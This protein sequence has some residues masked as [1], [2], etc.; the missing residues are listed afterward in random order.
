[1]ALIDTYERSSFGG[2][3]FPFTDLSIK[4]SLDHHVHKYLHRPGG[5][6][7]NLARHLYEF[8]FNCDFHDRY[9]THPTLIPDLLRLIRLFESGE[10]QELVVPGAGTFRAKAIDWTRNVTN[11][12]RSGGRVSI[13]FMEDSTDEFTTAT[14]VPTGESNSLPQIA[15]LFKQEA[16]AMGRPDLGNR[17]V[18]SV[19]DYISA[20]NNL[21]VT[22]GGS[23]VTVQPVINTCKSIS[24]DGAFQSPR[25]AKAF[26]VLQEVGAT[27]IGIAKSNPLSPTTANKYTTLSPISVMELAMQFY[28]R[29][30]RAASLLAINNFTDA[31]RIPAGSVINVLPM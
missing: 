20:R 6:I 8:K 9:R 26:M 31:L 5:E 18:L 29:S 17:L 30:D 3:K 14:L 24:A 15:T 11:M 25:N 12:V 7:E 2:I 21:D 19:N 1:M 23:P 27:A 4:G 10:T 13:T 28:G 22:A 16:D